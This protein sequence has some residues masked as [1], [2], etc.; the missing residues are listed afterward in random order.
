MRVVNLLNLRQNL[1]QMMAKTSQNKRSYTKLWLPV[2][3]RRNA[4]KWRKIKENQ[5]FQ[6]VLD[7]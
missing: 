5:H 7:I 3:C 6:G 4:E 2:L 1:R